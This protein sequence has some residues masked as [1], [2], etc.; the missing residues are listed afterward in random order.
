VVIEQNDNN[1]VSPK[2][3][4]F[5]ST[6]SNTYIP[7]EVVDLS[8]SM[9]AGGATRLSATNRPASGASTRCVFI[10]KA[11]NHQGIRLPTRFW[12]NVR[13]SRAF[14]GVIA[15]AAFPSVPFRPFP[16]N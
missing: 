6:K 5:F 7:P 16:A 4:V 1:L 10:K 11:L 14:R 8:R 12:C 2:V 15:S 13:Q 9:G 3:K